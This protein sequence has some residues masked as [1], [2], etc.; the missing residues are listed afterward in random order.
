M[1]GCGLGNGHD[2]P[3]ML[4]AFQADQASGE[5]LD[6]AGFSMDDEN[7]EAGVMVEVRVAG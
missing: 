5:F 3:P 2:E 4:H 6:A 1:T 7:L